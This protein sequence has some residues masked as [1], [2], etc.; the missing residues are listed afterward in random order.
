VS[1][2]TQF[3]VH[4]HC[5]DLCGKVWNPA[6]TWTKKYAVFVT[7]ENDQGITGLGECWCFDTTPDVLVAYLKT[8]ICP[9]I[10]GLDTAECAQVYQK[11]LSRATLTARHGLLASAWSGI[12]IALWDM[13]SRMAKLPLWKYIAQQK[14]DDAD[15]AGKV[16]LYSSG[17]L[18]GKDKTI[19]DLVIEMQSMNASG[20]DI[21]K[22]KVGGLSIREDLERVNAILAGIN[23]SCKLIIDGVYSYTEAEALEIYSALP[24]ERIEAFQSPVKACKHASMKS[25]TDAGVP[26]MATEAEYRTEIHEQLMKTGAVKYLQT[27]PIACGGIDR[28]LEL[29]EQVIRAG[30]DIELSLEVSSTAIALLAACH[31][32]A[33]IPAVTHVEYHYIHQVFFEH[34]DLYSISDGWLQL[35]EHVGLGMQLPESETQLVFSET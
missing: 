29:N 35:P 14:S 12:D 17:G 33:C 32:G 3:N 28:L 30:T 4:T 15:A 18:Y 7:L 5:N 24:A 10:I 6:I 21:V 26:V 22:M 23:S 13:Q 34:L 19:E 16:K 9:H 31:L 2:I 8:E 11:L 1:V 25:L 27:A 20:F